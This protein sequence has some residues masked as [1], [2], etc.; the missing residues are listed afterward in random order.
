MKAALGICIALALVAPAHAQTASYFLHHSD[1][2][3]TVPGGS[4]TFFLDQN[5]PVATTPTVEERTVSSGGAVTF[6]SFTSPAFGSDTTLLPIASVRLLLSANQKMRACADLSADLFKLDAGGTPT[7][8]GGATVL[9]ETIP[10][11]KAGGTTGFDGFRVEFALSD[12]SLLTGQGLAVAPSLTSHCSVN[13]HVF[14]AYDADVAPSRVV[15]QCCF[16]VQAKCAAAKIKAAAKKA[17]CLLKL[18]STQAAKGKAADPD[19]VQKCHDALSITFT[20][21]EAK[22]NCITTGDAGTIESVVDAFTGNV[23]ASLNSSGPP[24]ANKCQGAKIKVAAKKTSCLLGLK[25]KAAAKGQ[26][27]DPLDPARVQKCVD[28]FSAAFTK[29]ESS[30]SCLTTGDTGSTETKVDTFVDDVAAGLACPCD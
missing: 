20:K 30:G 7:T 24:S 1:T 16:T 21:L 3:V 22:G 4:T 11:G 5:A 14:L 19:K 2:P 17:S 6:P 26:F 29:A 15:F 23:D 25:A 28:T 8:I 12:R 27:T 9:A 10:Q 13:R 18:D